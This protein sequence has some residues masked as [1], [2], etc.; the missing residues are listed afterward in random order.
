MQALH[1]QRRKVPIPNHRDCRECCHRVI[2]HEPRDA[3]NANVLLLAVSGTSIV[4]PLA[5]LTLGSSTPPMI[6]TSRVLSLKRSSWSRTNIAGSF[7]D[8]IV[9]R[10][11]DLS[12]AAKYTL[13]SNACPGLKESVAAEYRGTM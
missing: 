12:S 3:S 8:A 10:V 6:T 1:F 5:L 11:R 4:V 9:T 13:C 7:K 2:L